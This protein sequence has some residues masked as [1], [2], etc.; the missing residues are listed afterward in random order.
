MN[1][2]KIVFQELKKKKPE[3]AENQRKHKEAQ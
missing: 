2:H 1:N 3:M